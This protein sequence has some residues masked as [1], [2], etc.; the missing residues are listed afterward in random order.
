MSPLMTPERELER[1]SVT[2][3]RKRARRRLDDALHEEEQ[4]AVRYAAA[5]GTEAE[6]GAYVQLRDAKEEVAARDRWLEWA[7]SE[8]FVTPWPDFLPIHRLLG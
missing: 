1:E 7:E 6:L 3:E 4:S 2:D 5:E 8:E